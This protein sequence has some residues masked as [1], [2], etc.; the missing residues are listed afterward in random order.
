MKQTNKYQTSEGGPQKLTGTSRTINV[1]H[2]SMF[3]ETKTKMKTNVG[4]VFF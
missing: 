4:D 1:L 2:E 3:L